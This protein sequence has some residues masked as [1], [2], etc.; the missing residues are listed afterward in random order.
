MK[1]TDA[2]WLRNNKFFYSKSDEPKHNQ[3]QTEQYVTVVAVVVV[4]VA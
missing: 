3:T 1:K 4:V 2:N